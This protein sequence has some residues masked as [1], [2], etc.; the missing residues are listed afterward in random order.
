M[1]KVF[2][3]FKGVGFFLWLFSCK[4]QWPIE[5]KQIFTGLLHMLWFTEFGELG[6]GAYRTF[7]VPYHFPLNNLFCRKGFI[8]GNLTRRTCIHAWVSVQLWYFNLVLPYTDVCSTVRV[9]V[10]SGLSRV[11]WKSQAILLRWDLN[12]QPLQL[13]SSVLLMTYFHFNC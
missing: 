13:L 1:T 3:A 12:P 10:Y 11:L 4:L 7:I 8:V 5:P 2:S 9:H 6:L